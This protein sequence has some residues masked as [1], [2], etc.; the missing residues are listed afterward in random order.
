MLLVQLQQFGAYPP[1]HQ[2]PYSWWKRGLV[3]WAT[4]VQSLLDRRF[5]NSSPKPAAKKAVLEGSEADANDSWWRAEQ[6]IGL[7]L[8]RLPG[9]LLEASMDGLGDGRLHQVNVAHHKGDE[10]V[11][12]VFVERPIAQVSC[13]RWSGQI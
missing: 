8:D 7:L 4:V 13:E 3:G 12:Q 9:L 6:V 2:V 11:L 5:F 10:Q 1:P